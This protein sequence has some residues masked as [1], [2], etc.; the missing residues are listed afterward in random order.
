MYMLDTNICSYILKQRPTEVLQKFEQVP[1]DKICIS[2]VTYA[3][4]EYGVEKTFSKQM[5]QQIIEAFVDRLIVLPWDMD[6]AKHYAKIRSN[7]EKKGTPIGN[8]D[9]MIASH[10][11]SQKCTLVTNNVREFER[12]PDLKIENWAE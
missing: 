3:E 5:N 8:M 11:R 1:K 6:A 12:V 4:L 7:L 9:L 10:A 2:I